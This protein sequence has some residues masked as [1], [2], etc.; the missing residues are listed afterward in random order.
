[1]LVHSWQNHIFYSVG[2]FE[3]KAGRDLSCPLRGAARSG[4]PQHRDLTFFIVILGLHPS[5]RHESNGGPKLRFALFLF[6]YHFIFCAARY[7]P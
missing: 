1:M 5:I 3:Q 6:D 2:D 7:A 4:A